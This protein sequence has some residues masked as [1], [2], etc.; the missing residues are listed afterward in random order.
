MNKS[1]HGFVTGEKGP[2]VNTGSHT[3][4]GDEATGVH[5]Q[6][7]YIGSKHCRDGEQYNKGQTKTSCSD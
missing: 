2:V 5:L 7:G 1:F 3:R 4:L 6:N